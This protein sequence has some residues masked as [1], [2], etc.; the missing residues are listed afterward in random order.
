MPDSHPLELDDFC[1]RDRNE[2]TTG[3]RD[4]LDSCGFLTAARRIANKLARNLIFSNGQ[5]RF[6][7]VCDGFVILIRRPVTG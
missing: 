7:K 1:G 2:L 5:F 3:W 4:G 6:K